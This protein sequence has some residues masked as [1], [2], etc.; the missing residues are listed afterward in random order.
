MLDNN[1]IDEY[2]GLERKDTITDDEAACATA[3]IWALRSKDPSTQVG[4]CIY[5]DG[6]LLSIGYNRP[7]RGWSDSAFFWGK[8]DNPLYGKYP[9]IIHAEHSAISNYRGYK[10]DLEG[11]TM[12]VTLFPCEQ[13]AQDI[14]EAGIKK[15]IYINTRGPIENT[16]AMMLLNN[17]GIEVVSLRDV[18]SVTLQSLYLSTT[19]TTNGA[20]R[21]KRRLYNGNTI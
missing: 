11:S 20:V 8:P 21:S 17:A 3:M 13:C 10:H 16:P 12:L 1:N 18:A 19:P 14:A 5:K 4:A 15:L 6:V 9:Y 2:L 7:P